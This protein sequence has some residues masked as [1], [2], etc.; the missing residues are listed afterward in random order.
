MNMTNET[1][2]EYFEILSFNELSCQIG[3]GFTKPK[4]VPAFNPRSISGCPVTTADI[5]RQPE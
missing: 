3:L 2:F 5:A 1:K 4:K